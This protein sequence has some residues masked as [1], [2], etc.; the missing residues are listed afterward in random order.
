M[1]KPERRWRAARDTAQFGGIVEAG[2][3][4][5][6]GDGS[7]ANRPKCP[8]THSRIAFFCS[9]AMRTEQPL[10]ARPIHWAGMCQWQT[11]DG[12]Q[13]AGGKSAVRVVLL[14]PQWDRPPTIATVL[15]RVVIIAFPAA[16]IV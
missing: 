14:L 9:S 3:V 12:S 13:N 8:P 1:A 11:C 5:R 10:A 2:C 6:D 15:H 16:E 4:D 7:R